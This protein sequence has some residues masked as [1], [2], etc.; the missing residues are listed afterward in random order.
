MANL[1]RITPLAVVVAF[2]SAL[3]S[4][5]P[6][7]AQGV[8]A[9]AHERAKVA[10]GEFRGDLRGLPRVPP[11]SIG[12][13]LY[14]E[15][16][17]VPTIRK[18]VPGQATPELPNSPLAPMPGATQSFAGMSFNDSCAGGQC[19]AGWPPDV[20]GDVGRDHY[21]QA[22]NDAYAVYD[23]TGTLLA[24][25][26]ENQLWSNSGAN[27][28]NGNS[29]GDPVVLYDQ[30]AD[31]WILTHF[32]FAIQANKPAS[33]FYECIAVSKT[34]DPIAGGWWLYPLRMDPG[35]TGLPPVGALNDYPKFGIWTDCLFM[36]ANEFRMP[37]GAFVGTAFASFSLSDLE[38]GATL[39][40]GLGFINNTRN[41][42]TM[43]PSNLLGSSPGA[44]PP[45]GT[46]NYFVSES[47]LAF[48]FEVRKFA[49]GANCGGGGT[50]SGPTQVSQA[51]YS[52]IPGTN[53][54]QPNTTNLLDSLGDRLMQKVQYRKVGSAESL[55][56][57]HTVS[58][59]GSPNKLQWAQIDVTGSTIA[60]T[61]VQQQEYA[62]DT[63]LHRWMGSLAVD[64][65]GNMAVG[66]STSNG[67]SPN[68]PSIAYSGRLVSDPLNQLPQSEVQM[69]AGAGSQTNSCGGAPC[70]RW[71]DYTAMS[72]DPADD[73]TFWYTNEYY[74]SQ[75]NGTVG[76]WQ[77]LIGSF[78]F[79]SCGAVSPTSTPTATPTPAA[80][81]TLGTTTPTISATATTT[82]TP[83]VTTT[84]TETPTP[85]L[86]ATPTETVTPTVTPTPTR[87]VTPTVTATATPTATPTIT[88]TPTHTATPAVTTTPTETPTP[89]LTATP[90]ETVTPTVTPTPT[91][92]VT[93]TVTATAT[94]TATP[95]ITAAPTH[96]ATPT[97]TTTPSQITT[98]LETPST[99][100]TVAV[101][102]TPSPVPPT[103]SP[104]PAGAVQLVIGD[105]A[106]VGSDFCV[107]VGLDNAST[108]VQSVRATLVDVPDE[109][110]LTG[111]TCVARAAGFSCAAS[112]TVDN[113]ILLT[114]EGQGAQCMASGAGTIARVCLR[115]AAPVCPVVSLVDLN[116]SDVTAT[117]C[118]PQP[119]QTCAQNGSVICEVLGDCAIDNGTID[120]FDVLNQIDIILG[121]AAPTSAETVVCDD[122]CDATIDI[123]D[124]LEGI[125]AI[126]GV[127]PQPL[128]CPPPP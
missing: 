16:L 18:V 47:Q 10:P 19:G 2:L 25:F 3:G 29:Q 87:T 122:T 113:R 86:T 13:R 23:K 121:R 36:A 112:E 35:G 11:V 76:N 115:D 21:I 69:I 30:L 96:T 48:S 33:P 63:A 34:S 74:S 59:S 73:C 67:T 42:F 26:T 77:T 6:A 95:T 117:D 27:P 43:I 64:G 79:P 91:R 99:T 61:P 89:T 31:R 66:Y 83:T 1:P 114:V 38:S 105:T 49:P 12:P 56:V 24:S 110:T 101:T 92:T 5:P 52:A 94:P 119:L 22:V 90:T 37:S 84:P 58:D 20:N 57:V 98:P 65:Q 127:V 106:T 17:R 120:I 71:G 62:P 4:F 100:P 28:C 85:T 128:T 15:L 116:V 80:T 93:P 126:L 111:V 70:H 53:V 40:W 46:P 41:P 8:D 72:V 88:A 108:G 125:D 44:L 54:P 60:T 68:F 9:R 104:C 32:A 123:F 118:A 97:V 103:P 55:W 102:A 107:D 50:L 124:V 75:T 14:R 82:S 109:F 39:T 45:A 81:P 51:S 7:A 78:K